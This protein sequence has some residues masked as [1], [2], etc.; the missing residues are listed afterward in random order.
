MDLKL[1]LI[2]KFKPF[3]FTI[4]IT[5]CFYW[6]SK[7]YL[8][9][10][11]VNPIEAT[12]HKLGEFSLRLLILT[13]LITPLTQISSLRNLQI[14]RRMVGLFA[15]FYIC[16]HLSSYI[17]LDHFF[18]WEFILKDVYK[19]PFI[20][21][22]FLAF[23]FTIPLALTSNNTLITKLTYKVWKKIHRLIYFIAPLAGLHYYLLTKAD[24]TKPIIYLTLISL[25]LLSRIIIYFSKKTFFS[26]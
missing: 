2:K 21:L 16:L 8:G 10:M 20:T 1:S 9:E 14:L 19:R 3:L 23:L 13:L 18:N 4:L 11:G 25:L 22:G 5:P 15:F 17:V 12:I 24:K 6:F 7:L 26:R